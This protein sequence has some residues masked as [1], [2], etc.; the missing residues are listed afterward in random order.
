MFHS[1]NIKK[2]VVIDGKLVGNVFVTSDESNVFE[3]SDKATAEGEAASVSHRDKVIRRNK[4][5]RNIVNYLKGLNNAEEVKE[6][7]RD[8]DV[9]ERY[10]QYIFG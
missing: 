2:G 10:I 6:V 1:D 5:V 8:S 3:V 4:L 9:K 7:L